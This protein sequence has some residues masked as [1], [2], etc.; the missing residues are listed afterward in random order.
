M[1]VS[2]YFII[3][4][5]CFISSGIEFLLTGGRWT[6]AN[7]DIKTM[8]YILISSLLCGL[9]VPD[10]TRSPLG[11]NTERGLLRCDFVVKATRETSHILFECRSISAQV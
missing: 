4:S 1:L 9:G 8:R 11:N 7:N 5:Y 2:A 10:I 3:N 6:F